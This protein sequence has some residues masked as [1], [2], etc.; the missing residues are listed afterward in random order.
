MSERVALD[1]LN[2]IPSALEDELDPHVLESLIGASEYVPRSNG[3]SAEWT[4]DAADLVADAADVFAGL[5]HAE[6]LDLTFGDEPPDLIDGLLPK[7]VVVTTAGLPETYKGWVCARKAAIVATGEGDLFGCQALT[8]GAAGYFWQDD[9]TRNE[10][11][12]VQ[13]YARVHDTPRDLPIRWFLNEGLQ[14]PRDL[15]RLRA[16]IE[17]FGFVYVVL[18]SFYNIAGDLD[19]KDREAGAVF[20]AIKTEICDPTG[21]TV[22]VV[23]HMPWANDTNRKRLRGY[24]D[25]FKNAAVRAGLY[26]DAD[27]NKLYVEARGNNIRGFKRTP[28]YWYLDRL[29]LR[30]VEA[31][32]HNELVEKKAE[33]IAALLEAE[34]ART[35]ST[36]AIRNAVKGGHGTVDQALE[37]LKGRGRVQTLPNADAAGSGNAGKPRGWYA[38]IHTGLL[39]PTTLPLDIPAGFGR[40]ESGHQGD[41]PATPPIG[42]RVLL[43][44]GQTRA[45]NERADA[46]DGLTRARGWRSSA[47]RRRGRGAARRVDALG[48]G[49]HSIWRGCIRPICISS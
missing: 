25:V 2:S 12:R 17:R 3:H 1:Q 21:C 16:T 48:S 11:E 47:R 37:L 6:V 30:L 43:R 5:A 7:G 13:L 33:Q 31:G 35:Y 44:Q 18:D 14:L 20:A 39:A 22:D 46:S 8:Q 24:G 38:T 26:I 45:T 19:L 40:V 36:T 49:S 27:G 10:A 42:G 23:D 4:P 9:S 34:P 41:N 32:D 29:E 28:A 15:D